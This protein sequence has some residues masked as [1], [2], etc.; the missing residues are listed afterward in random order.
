[1]CVVAVVTGEDFP[2]PSFPVVTLTTGRT[3]HR[4]TRLAFTTGM[5]AR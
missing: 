4:L 3:W 2:S 5:L 1:V